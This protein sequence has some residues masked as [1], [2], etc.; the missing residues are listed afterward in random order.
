ML[1]SRTYKSWDDDD[2]V[3]N[4]DILNYP[5]VT[6]KD[7]RGYFHGP[8]ESLNLVIDTRTAPALKKSNDAWRG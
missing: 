3:P 5:W 7:V 2:E 1:S 8:M 6:I 4:T